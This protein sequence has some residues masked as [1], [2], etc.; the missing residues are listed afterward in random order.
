MTNPRVMQTSELQTSI[1]SGL[2]L[3]SDIIHRLRLGRY[4]LHITFLLTQSLNSPSGLGRYWPISKELARLG[5]QVSILALHHDFQTVERRRYFQEGVEIRYVG[6]MHVLKK[7]RHKLHFGQARLIW[8]SALA[9]WNLTRA[10]LQISADVYHVGKPHPM[11]GI[12]G[13]LAAR[14][15]NVPLVVD[16]DD[17][18]AG[19]NRY[20][21]RWQ[22]PVV[23]W[24]EDWLPGQAAAV[25]VNTRFLEDRYAGMRNRIRKVVRVTNGVDH[26]RFGPVRQAEIQALRQEWRLTGKPVVAYVGTM[27]LISHPIDL[28]INAFVETRKAIPGALLLL[29]G[30]G[31]DY[32][33]LT[34][35][36]SKV[37]LEDSVRFVGPVEPHQVP[38]YLAVADVSVDPVH[39]DLNA[40]ARSPLKVFESLAVG[41]PVVTGDVGDRREILQG[42]AA[43]ELV[44]P[45]QAAA[46]AEGIIKVLTDHQ[47]R[48]EMEQNALEIIKRYYWDTLV[49]DFLKAY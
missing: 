8:V 40:R 32:P 26:D 46:L 7:G 27:S 44:E 30:S 18:E 36:V 34:A 14:L 10:A 42:G 1:S 37:G 15:H 4:S 20:S 49:E 6:Q 11:N 39:D 38:A 3:P 16:C 5:H 33:F 43:G 17:Y 23:R 28:L 47:L 19:S 12:A 21:G 35:L 2:R 22:R 41:T 9:T 13:W 48:Y 25:T 31:D 24:F 29:V 45:G